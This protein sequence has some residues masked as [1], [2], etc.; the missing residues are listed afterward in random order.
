MLW[1]LLQTP[2]V[3][4]QMGWVVSAW[5]ES[6]LLEPLG[7][8]TPTSSLPHLPLAVGAASNSYLEP[9]LRLVL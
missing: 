5:P 8:V 6:Q 1:F 4:A 7:S 3:S 9:S 2:E